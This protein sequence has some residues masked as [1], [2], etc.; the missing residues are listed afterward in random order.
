MFW[1]Q[2]GRAAPL[3]VPGLLG[4]AGTARVQPCRCPRAAHKGSLESRS[5]SGFSFR[6]PCSCRVDFSF[7][8]PEIAVILK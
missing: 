3:A 1:R 7:L 8:S 6:P 5:G 2:F 4:T